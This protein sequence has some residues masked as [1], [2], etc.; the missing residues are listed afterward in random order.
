MQSIAQGRLEH[1]DKRL[2]AGLQTPS[3]GYV[4]GKILQPQ[5]HRATLQGDGGLHDFLI[6]E[7]QRLG[8]RALDPNGSVVH[9]NHWHAWCA[10]NVV[11][12]KY[13]IKDFQKNGPPPTGWAPRLT[14]AP[15]A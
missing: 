13:Q 15:W 11:R 6:G 10:K 9:L 2:I 8:H 5:P 3:G 12:T 14:Q 1:A 7:T 4:E